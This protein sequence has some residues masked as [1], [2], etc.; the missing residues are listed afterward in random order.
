MGYFSTCH[1]KFRILPL[2]IILLLMQVRHVVFLLCQF[3]NYME[4]TRLPVYCPSEQEKDD[5]KL[6]AD[7]IRKL[8]AS[9][10]CAFFCI[11]KW[12]Y[13]WTYN[14]IDLYYSN[15]VETLS[16]LVVSILFAG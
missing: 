10:V 2:L 8:M 12:E 15:A 6:Y 4:V 7:N 3:V 16:Y 9:E 5:P 11:S 14:W 1:Y 13:G